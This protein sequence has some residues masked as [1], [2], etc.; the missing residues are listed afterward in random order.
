[1]PAPVWARFRSWSKARFFSGPTGQVRIETSRLVIR[2]MEERD[3]DAFLAYVNDP[4]IDR[5]GADPEATNLAHAL[6]VIRFARKQISKRR[7]ASFRFG[8]EAIESNGL[9]GDCTLNLRYRGLFQPSPDIATIGFELHRK[10]WG[11]GYATEA[12]RS[13]LDFA[14]AE[15]GV[16]TVYGGCH[17]EN[18]AS[19][20]VMEKAGMAQTGTQFGFPGGPLEVAS[21]VFTANRDAWLSA[22]A[23]VSSEFELEEE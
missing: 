4:E 7:R 12:A 22:D 19:Q 9:I 2:E 18:I 5:F 6:S 3:A 15:M 1:M 8:I 20:R 21:L 16:V 11:H 23:K 14:F 17:P 10:D 13:I